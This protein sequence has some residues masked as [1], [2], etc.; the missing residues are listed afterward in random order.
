MSI[1][2]VKS[3]AKLWI[4]LIWSRSLYVDKHHILSQFSHLILQDTI[5]DLETISRLNTPSTKHHSARTP[6]GGEGSGVHRAVTSEHSDWPMPSPSPRPSSA[7]EVM[8]AL[9]AQRA[10]RRPW[11]WKVLNEHQMRLTLHVAHLKA[12]GCVCEGTVPLDLC[13]PRVLYV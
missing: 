2:T 12:L 5:A 8:P 11:S 13:S 1:Q 9:S 6:P 4:V 7:R 10:R 3:P